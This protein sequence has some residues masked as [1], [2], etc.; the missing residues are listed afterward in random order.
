MYERFTDRARKTMQLAHQIA[1]D[2]G[3]DIIRTGHVL[4][5]LMQ[6]DSS[7]VREILKHLN[8]DP[9][10][11]CTKIEEVLAQGVPSNPKDKLASTPIVKD[12]ICLAM[13]ESRAQQ[14]NYVGTEHLLV[15]LSYNPSFSIAAKILWDV[16]ATTDKIREASQLLYLTYNEDDAK[17]RQ[18]LEEVAKRLGLRTTNDGATF[19]QIL[20]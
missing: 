9:A 19:Q 8:I 4:L 10:V 1:Q 15:A 2:K 13:D 14:R 20:R 5:G 16:G 6:A 7:S 11:I 12:V 18:A 17:I 3:H